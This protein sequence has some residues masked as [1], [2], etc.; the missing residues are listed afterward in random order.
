MPLAAARAVVSL[1]ELYAV[2]GLLFA[3]CFL[4]RAVTRVDPGTAAAPWTMRL[5]ILPGVAALW[6]LL[7]RRWLTGVPPPVERTAH[8]SRATPR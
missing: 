4:P 5:L 8:R 3:L 7:A 6:P 1:I 2:A